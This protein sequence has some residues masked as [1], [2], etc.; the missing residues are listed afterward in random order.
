LRSAAQMVSY[1]IAMGV[2]FACIVLM[3]GSLNLSEIIY[4]Q[5][6]I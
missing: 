3:V 4:S 5:K 2:M 6:N 1:E